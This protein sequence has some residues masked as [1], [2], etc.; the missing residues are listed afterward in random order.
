MS[1]S[2]QRIQDLEVCLEAEKIK[3]RDLELTIT[4]FEHQKDNMNQA[5]EEVRQAYQKVSLNF[6]VVTANNSFFGT[7]RKSMS[8][9]ILRQR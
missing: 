2:E 4:E 7:F 6:E 8:W 9:R 5:V 1:L 3:N